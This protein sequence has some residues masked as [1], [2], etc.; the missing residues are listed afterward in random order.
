MVRS[1]LRPCPDDLRSRTTPNFRADPRRSVDKRSNRAG[2]V[3]VNERTGRIDVYDRDA[4]RLGDG[5]LD[6]RT[7]R[8]DLFDSWG[9]R[10][11]TRTQSD[12]REQP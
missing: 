2:G 4:N 9:N 10:I 11:G 1:I 8:V 7:G 5:Q 6:R 12:V 3:I